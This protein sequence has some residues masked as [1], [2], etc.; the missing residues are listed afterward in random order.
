MSARD[1]LERERETSILFHGDY[2]QM[3]Q[4]VCLVQRRFAYRCLYRCCFDNSFFVLA[5][6]TAMLIF[7]MEIILYGMKKNVLEQCISQVRMRTKH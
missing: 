1:I 4:S 5:C 6:A 3:D 2:H 7:M